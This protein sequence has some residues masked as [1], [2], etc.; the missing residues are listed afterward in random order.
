MKSILPFIH[1]NKSLDRAVPGL[2]LI[3]VLFILIPSRNLT[4]RTSPICKKQSL[5]AQGQTFRH[6][7]IAQVGLEVWGAFSVKLQ[8]LQL[9]ARFPGQTFRHNRI[10]QVVE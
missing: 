2:S 4:N 10:T 1:H 6:N 7:R 8:V 9:R 5:S 3:L